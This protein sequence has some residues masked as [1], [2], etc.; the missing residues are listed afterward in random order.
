MNTIEKKASQSAQAE[1]SLVIEMSAEEIELIS[2]AEPK[3]PS[4]EIW[5][6]GAC[7]GEPTGTYSDMVY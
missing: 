4:G 3:F 6:A 1:A 5:C 2:G 7:S